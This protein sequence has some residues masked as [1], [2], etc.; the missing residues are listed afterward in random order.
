[1]TT[2]THGFQT[3]V[4]QLLQLMI[5]SL[6][7][8]RDIF[9]RELISNAADAAD[10][11]RFKALEN[12]DLYEGDGDL[13]VRIK[14]D[15]DKGTLTISDNGIG[16]TESEIVEHLGTI[17]K[18]GTKAFFQSLSGDAAKD[19]Q[20]IGQFGVGFY[21]AFIVAD[22]VEVH[23]RAAGAK[24][25]VMWR[26]KG[27]GTFETGPSDKTS[28]GTDIVLF[29]KDDDKDFL[30]SY[31]LE[32][33][34]HT[35]S[36]HIG[37]PVELYKEGKEEGEDGGFAPVNQGTALWTKS[38][39]EV[40]DE[41][42]VSFY[43]H[44]S[45]DFGEPLTWSHNKVEGKHE[46]TSLLYIPKN[47]PWDLYQRERQHGLKLYVKRVFIMDDAEVFLPQYLRFVKGLVDSADLP[48]NVSREILQDSKLTQSMKGA[49]SKRILSMLE[50]LA[51][52]KP[53]DYA[54]FWKNFGA[55]LKEGP[56]EDFA[57]REAIAGL[58]RF[59]STHHDDTEHLV[60]LD[61]YLERMPEGQD[62]IYYVVAD[63]FNAARFS[64]HLEVLRKKGFEVLLLSERIDDWMM[65]HLTEYK[66]KP[67]ASAT[68]GELDIEAT[69]EEKEAEKAI[70]GVLA[71]VKDSLGDKVS[72]VRFTHR[73]TDSPAC[74]VTDEHG[75]SS[76]MAKLLASVGQAAPEVK[77][78]FELNPEHPVVKSLDGREG[79][80]FEDAVALLFEQALLAERG[81]L[82]DPSGF[83]KRL[84]KLMLQGL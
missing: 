45:H 25:G 11:L 70:E 73:L 46:Y 78:I 82:E 55:V 21:S 40:S 23:S 18:S 64:P 68:R 65:S 81:S 67:F 69:D 80:N 72:E 37:V 60:S 51:K 58:L 34:I 8:N 39:S 1:M 77:Y 38:K 16:M 19:S 35:Y 63:S 31:K 10:K 15:K 32:Q 5:H 54:G 12:A 74:V 42:Y 36:D 76:Q 59:N 84:N 53:E 83:V 66:G 9:L 52:D 62:K 56:A 13:K 17:A 44:L 14:A 4:Q 57:N 43:Q 27:E 48:L 41:E 22:T 61:E 6:Y 2:Q 33:V 20:L 3:E 7:S 28:R 79:E 30:E 49:I 50:K 47:A 24:E 71:K 29:L 26:S 75:M